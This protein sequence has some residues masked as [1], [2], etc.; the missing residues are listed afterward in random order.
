M[1]LGTLNA[2]ML[3]QN[4]VK[5]GTVGTVEDLT[6]SPG[7]NNVTMAGILHPDDDDALAAAADFMSTYMNNS[8]QVTTVRG[9]D[10]GDT[11]INWLNDIVNG[12]E[13]STVFPGGERAGKKTSCTRYHFSYLIYSNSPLPAAGDDFAALTEIEII[14]M[15]ME[16]TSDSHAKVASTVK[17]RLNVPPQVSQSIIMNVTFSGMVFDLIDPD[18][19]SHLG[20]LT[21]DVTDVPVTYEN[22]YITATFEKTDMAI[23]DFEGTQDLIAQLMVNPDKTVRMEGKASPLVETGMGWLQL[24]DVPFGGEVRICEERTTT[25]RSERQQRGAKRRGCVA[26]ATR[27]CPALAPLCI[28]LAP[29]IKNTLN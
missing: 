20:G 15:E 9:T 21:L 5:L 1:V 17:A 16:L 26:R 24:K 8:A 4:K 25:T 29:R 13:L 27:F 3:D 23:K 14:A 22:G 28:A 7:V 11:P 19:S 18:T 2:E 12:L 6:L 10:A